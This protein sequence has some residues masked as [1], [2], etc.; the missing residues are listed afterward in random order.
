M[1]EHH[2]QVMQLLQEYLEAKAA[3]LQEQQQKPDPQLQGITRS[4]CALTP[5]GT[6]SASP[7]KHRNVSAYYL[8]FFDR[9]GLLVDCGMCEKPRLN[10]GLNNGSNTLSV[11]CSMSHQHA[12]RTEHQP[13]P[14]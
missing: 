2:P 11:L 14:C 1:R 12:Y 10:T 8:D 7:T 3:V 6:C 13:A 5:L 9:G 4:T